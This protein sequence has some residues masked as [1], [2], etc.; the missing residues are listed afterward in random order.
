MTSNVRAVFAQILDVPLKVGCYLNR[1]GEGYFGAQDG[2]GKGFSK[3]GCYL[4][5]AP[6][7]YLIGPIWGK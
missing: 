3:I 7:C 1:L 2:I 6:G 5:G 4:I